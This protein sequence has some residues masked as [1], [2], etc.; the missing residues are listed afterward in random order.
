MEYDKLIEEANYNNIEIL[1]F[2]FKGNAKGYYCDGFIALNKKIDTTKEKKCILAEELGHYY[3]G[4]GNLLSD[5]ILCK[6]K[7]HLARRWASERLI[8]LQDFINAFNYGINSKVDLANYLDVTEDFLECTINY[9]RK[10][11][12]ASITIDK[13]IIIFEPNL[14]VLKL[15]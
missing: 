2:P 4:C 1:E 10:K 9:Y 3:T 14:A 7:E 12:G 13:Y 8:T 11:Y 5:S 6:K 15:F